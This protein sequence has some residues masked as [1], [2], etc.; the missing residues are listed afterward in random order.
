MAESTMLNWV[1]VS[2]HPYFTPFVMVNGWEYLLSSYTLIFMQSRNCRTIA[3][4]LAGITNLAMISHSVKCLSQVVYS[5]TFCSR[6]LSCSYQ[7][8]KTMSVWILHRMQHCGQCY[9]LCRIY[10]SSQRAGILR[11]LNKTWA[12]IFAAMKIK[13]MQW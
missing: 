10:V 11:R 2:T 6:Y 12:R 3:T 5:Q 8:V 9:I 7:A 1:G 13:K 4:N